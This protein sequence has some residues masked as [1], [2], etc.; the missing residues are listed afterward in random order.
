MV[1]KNEAIRGKIL[2]DRIE[3]RLPAAKVRAAGWTRMESALQAVRDIGLEIE[4]PQR[5][6]LMPVQDGTILVRWFD[7]GA[8]GRNSR[9]FGRLAP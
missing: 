4:E 8:A 3:I 2:C 9:Q 7:F 1:H 6:Q 5:I